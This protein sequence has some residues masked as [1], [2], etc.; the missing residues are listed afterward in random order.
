M[1]DG[2]RFRSS[3]LLFRFGHSYFL[4]S[5]LTVCSSLPGICSAKHG[6]FC[7]CIDFNGLGNINDNATPNEVVD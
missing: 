7:G 1:W 3:H 2:S 5:L 6:S 4:F